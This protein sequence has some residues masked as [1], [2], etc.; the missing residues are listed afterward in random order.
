[1]LI[2]RAAWN[3]T[4]WSGAYQNILNWYAELCETELFADFP[5]MWKHHAA[6]YGFHPASA[7]VWLLRL[8]LI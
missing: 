1:M 5:F 8:K 2:Y 3:L 7:N 6:A 4:K